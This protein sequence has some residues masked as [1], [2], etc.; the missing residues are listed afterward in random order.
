MKRIEDFLNSNEL[1][2]NRSK[3]KIVECM[4]SQKRPRVKGAPPR[5]EVKDPEGKDMIIQA[6]EYTR[7]LGANYSQNLGWS[8]HLESGEKALLPEIRR[9]LGSLRHISGQIPA[10]SQAHPSERA[11]NEQGPLCDGLVG[12]GHQQGHQEGHRQPST[13]LQGGSPIAAKM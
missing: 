2:E 13:E 4:V 1:I 9:I 12:W 3:T 10:A 7:L 11:H 8:H 6:S 5:L